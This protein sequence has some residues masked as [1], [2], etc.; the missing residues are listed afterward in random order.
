MSPFNRPV[1]DCFFVPTRLLVGP[2][3]GCWQLNGWEVQ[4]PIGFILL[5]LFDQWKEHDSHNSLTA[6][7]NNEQFWIIFRPDHFDSSLWLLDLP[8]LEWFSWLFCHLLDFSGPTTL[9]SDRSFQI[10]SLVVWVCLSLWTIPWLVVSCILS[11]PTNPFSE[12]ASRFFALWLL[13]LPSL[14]RFRT[15]TDLCITRRPNVD[16]TSCKIQKKAASR[17]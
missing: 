6:E 5:L 15:N 1:F 7:N 10:F 14:E 13:H 4:R 16:A 11:P 3:N 17:T 12:R 9:L 2:L 8:S